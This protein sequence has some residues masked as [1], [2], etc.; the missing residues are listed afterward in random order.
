MMNEEI[1]AANWNRF[2]AVSSFFVLPSAFEISK[3][4]RAGIFVDYE[5][6]K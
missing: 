2:K 6:A 5:I 4:R 3:A 1:S